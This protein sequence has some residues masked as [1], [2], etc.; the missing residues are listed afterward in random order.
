VDIYVTTPAFE[1]A[2][3]AEG[4]DVGEIKGCKFKV[5]ATKDS[6]LLLLLATYPD[7][8]QEMFSMKWSF[9]VAPPGAY[10]FTSDHPV[11][12]WAPRDKRGPFN[13][14]GILN[15]DV[16]IIFPLTRRICV[17][18]S[19]VSAGKLYWPLTAKAVD[20]L[21][22]RTIWNGWHYVY[23]PEDLPSIRNDIGQRIKL[24]AQPLQSD[25]ESS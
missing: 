6:T 19:W 12:I 17:F 1:K 11:S 13:T 23:G 8:A 24:K 3:K 9:L 22:N 18:G 14:V 16:E 5:E 21:N 4:L 25:I 2:A 15:Q 7:I 10:F 20:Y